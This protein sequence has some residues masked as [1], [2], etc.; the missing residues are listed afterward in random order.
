LP[1]GISLQSKSY[2]ITLEA[3]K[4]GDGSTDWE[5]NQIKVDYNVGSVAGVFANAAGTGTNFWTLYEGNM[6]DGQWLYLGPAAAAA[7]ADDTAYWVTYTVDTQIIASGVPLPE[8]QGILL[9]APTILSGIAA[10]SA[11]ATDYEISNLTD[12]Q[13]LA[14][15]VRFV[16]PLSGVVI[17][18]IEVNTDGSDIDIGIYEGAEI[19]GTVL[20]LKFK[21]ENITAGVYN[22]SSEFPNLRIVIDDDAWRLGIVDVGVDALPA[23]TTVTVRGYPLI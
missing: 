21:R 23:N 2:T 3:S 8:G 10:T 22:S 1:H 12:G 11:P 9:T 4:T 14:A 19:T 16:P 6:A 20:N 7:T 18:Q 13:T 5:T 15:E 17:T